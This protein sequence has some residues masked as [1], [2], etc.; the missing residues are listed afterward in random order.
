MAREKILVIDSDLDALSRI[1]LALIHRKFKVEACNNPEEMS[2]RF[3]RFKPSV[4]I[5]ELKEYT[6]ISKK[7]KIPAVVLVEKQDNSITYLN[8]W[9]IQIQKPVHIEELMKAVEKLV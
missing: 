1:Y 9:D 7:L 3:K 2:A 5:L 8:D 4:I 6:A